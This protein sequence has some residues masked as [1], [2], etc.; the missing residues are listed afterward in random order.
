MTNIKWIKDN[1]GKNKINETFQE[2]AKEKINDLEKIIKFDENDKS[3]LEFEGNTLTIVNKVGTYK[4][5]YQD[6]GTYNT[7]IKMW[8]WAWCI[9][10]KNRSMNIYNNILHFNKYLHKYYD[11]FHP[12]EVDSYNFCSES[13]HFYWASD[14]L[15]TL[16]D[17]CVAITDCLGYIE[18]NNGNMIE[19]IIIKDLIKIKTQN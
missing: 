13:T 1:K 17:L 9:P 7:E 18:V 3:K 12:V 5:T 11:R 4:C 2:A 6:I 15:K 8:Y 19:Y 16:T 10:F 14:K